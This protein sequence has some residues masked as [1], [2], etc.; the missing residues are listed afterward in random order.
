M[1]SNWDQYK[2]WDQYKQKVKE[3]DEMIKQM[4]YDLH[5]GHIKHNCMCNNCFRVLGKKKINELLKEKEIE[6]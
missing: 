3:Q 5:V 2:H 4:N 6:K 1:N